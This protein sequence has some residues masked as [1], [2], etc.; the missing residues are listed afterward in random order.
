MQTDVEAL[1]IPLEL[2]PHFYCSGQKLKMGR[3]HKLHQTASFWEFLWRIQSKAGC[4]F[5][6]LVWQLVPVEALKVKLRKSRWRM[7]ID[8][9]RMCEV[10]RVQ[11]PAPSQSSA[12]H[13]SCMTERNSS[14]F[15]PSLIRFVRCDREGNHSQTAAKEIR[16]PTH[17][18]RFHEV[19]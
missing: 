19:N 5:S 3:D 8:S 7:W 17:Y 12:S 13:M 9:W 2:L 6:L 18:S 10:S 15:V 1:R 14:G 16:N 11:S 4:F